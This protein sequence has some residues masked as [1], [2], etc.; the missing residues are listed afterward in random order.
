MGGDI[1]YLQAADNKKAAAL[2]TASMDIMSVMEEIIFVLKL[3]RVRSSS[4]IYKR[5]ISRSTHWGETAY[6]G[7]CVS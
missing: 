6:A 2:S 5:V 4:F 3:K 1:V 7:G